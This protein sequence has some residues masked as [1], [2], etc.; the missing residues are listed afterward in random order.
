MTFGLGVLRADQA[1][2]AVDQLPLQPAPAIVRER[3]QFKQAS[4]EARGRA[5]PHEIHF[6]HA[7]VRS[8]TVATTPS[9]VTNGAVGVKS[10]TGAKCSEAARWAAQEVV[11]AHQQD[12]QPLPIG[13]FRDLKGQRGAPRTVARQDDVPTRTEA[14]AQGDVEAVDAGAEHGPVTHG[15]PG[16]RP[17][18]PGAC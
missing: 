11:I 17:V 10:D 5:A 1:L 2:G 6:D 3:N 14:A 4:N 8:K 12:G 13:A 15:S 16:R 9:G 7:S 18:C